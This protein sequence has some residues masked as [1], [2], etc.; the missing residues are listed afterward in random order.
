MF[1]AAQI[2][3]Q[4]MTHGLGPFADSDPRMRQMPSPNQSVSE[5][6]D[7]SDVLI[8]DQQRLDQERKAAAFHQLTMVSVEFASTLGGLVQKKLFEVGCEAGNGEAQVKYSTSTY[9]DDDKTVY[10]VEMHWDNDTPTRIQSKGAERIIARSELC[11]NR[12]NEER[13]KRLTAQRLM[14]DGEGHVQQFPT[15]SRYHYDAYVQ[16]LEARGVEYIKFTDGFNPCVMTADTK[17]DGELSPAQ[18]DVMYPAAVIETPT[19][20]TKMAA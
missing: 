17:N 14:E 1:H 3:F 19:M 9:V 10:R 2:D 15:G 12:D 11:P 13:L 8:L 20:L 5:A 6:S 4:N 7:L 16:Q 18:E